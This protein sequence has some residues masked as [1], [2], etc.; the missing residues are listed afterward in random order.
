[1]T[2]PP[3]FLLGASI[4]PGWRFGK[5]NLRYATR[6]AAT[7]AS[8]RRHAGDG[9]D[10]RFLE[11]SERSAADLTRLRRGAAGIGDPGGAAPGV[12]LGIETITLFFEVRH[13]R[14]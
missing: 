6:E 8:R 5:R 7:P 12:H 4:R 9:E 11:S 14:A 10:F 13:H 2:R 1:M 3:V